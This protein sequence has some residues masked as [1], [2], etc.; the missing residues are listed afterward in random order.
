MLLGKRLVLYPIG[1][2]DLSILYRWR[3]DV[4]FLHF[5]TVRRT[6]VD[7]EAFVHEIRQDFQIDRHLQ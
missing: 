1:E 4:S 3:N 6:I 2:K 5:C 7:Y